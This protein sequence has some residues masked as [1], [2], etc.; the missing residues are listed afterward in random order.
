MKYRVWDT[1]INRLFGTF[2]TE[3][4]AMTFVRTLVGRYGA[5]YAD[6]LAV[7]GE[8]A[9]GTYTAPLTGSALLARAEEVAAEQEPAESRRGEVIG[10]RRPKGGVGGGLPMTAK[11]YA[12]GAT[13]GR[14]QVTA[15]IRDRRRTG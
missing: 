12:C 5:A 2:E 7:G 15:P 8:R 14:K 1:D 10:S 9:D 13:R 6:D 11:G 4:E 3:A